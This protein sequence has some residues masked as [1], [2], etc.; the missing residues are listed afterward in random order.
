MQPVPQFPLQGRGD[1]AE[2][3]LGTGLTH[4]LISGV[5]LFKHGPF[6]QHALGAVSPRFLSFKAVQ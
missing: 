1:V 3:K 2:V 6:S 5:C 4:C